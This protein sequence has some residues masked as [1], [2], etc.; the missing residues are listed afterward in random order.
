MSEATL[1]GSIRETGKKGPA[2]RL[3][4]NGFVP[5]V[6][7]GKGETVPVSVSAKELLKL[8]D[9]RQI[10]RGLITVSFD[11]DKTKERR[12]LIKELTFHPVTDQLLH[13]DLW[14]VD[15]MRLITVKVGLEYTG[16]AKGV[17]LQGGLLAIARNVLVVRCLPENIPPYIEVAV[18]D[19]EIDQTLSI[20]DIKLPEGI[21]PIDDPELT[22]V[23]V[24][25]P[26]IEEEVEET[27]EGEAEEGAVET[28]AEGESAQEPAPGK[29]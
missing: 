3:R 19:L 9:Q 2:R 24:A 10:A 5:G 20:K 6:V 16:V 29:K 23:T 22:L 15:L 17:K 26:K 11:G 12:V 14:E 7:Y 25:E 21:E 28:P 27:P 18:D 8:L 13:L 4:A 1:T